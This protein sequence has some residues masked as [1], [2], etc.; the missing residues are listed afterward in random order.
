MDLRLKERHKRV[1]CQKRFTLRNI[2]WSG[3]DKGKNDLFGFSVVP[4]SY[5]GGES[6]GYLRTQ[7]EGMGV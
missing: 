4:K 7:M 5:S 6:P 1:E 2:G 3:L